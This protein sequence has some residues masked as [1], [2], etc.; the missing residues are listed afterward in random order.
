MNWSHSSLKQ[1]ENCPRQYHE[2]RILK[3]Y[4]REDTPETLYGE[5]VHA[6]AERF[7]REG[8]AIP[9]EYKFMRGIVGALLSKPGRKLAEHEMAL[10]VDLNVCDWKSKDAWVRG[11][12]DLLIVD[13]DALTAWVVDYKTGSNKYPDKGQL[14]LMS[15]L[16]FA[17]FP[18]IRKVNSAL[19]FVLR[20]DM[21]K[22]TM[23][24][25][26]APKWWQDYRERTARI[27]GSFNTGVWHPKSSGLCRKHCPVL[28]CEYNGRR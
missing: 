9:E 11:I 23:Y 22:D 24:V 17:H 21:V 20:E 28:G 27:Q 14:R 5:A 10:T 8:I 7:V 6:A 26:D 13:D 12:A 25:E 2:V 4:K 15:M 18:H 3:K 1:Y 19:L 16:T